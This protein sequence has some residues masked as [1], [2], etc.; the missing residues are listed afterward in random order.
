LN[1]THKYHDAQHG[2]KELGIIVK[3]VGIDFGQ[4]MK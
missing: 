3:D 2:F 1:A 4:L